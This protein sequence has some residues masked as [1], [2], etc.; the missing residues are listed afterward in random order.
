MLAPEEWAAKTVRVKSMGQ[1]SQLDVPLG[2]L[3]DLLLRQR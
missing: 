2:E 1:G 3:E